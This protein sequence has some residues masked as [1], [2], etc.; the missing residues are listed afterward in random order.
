MVYLTDIH[1]N[2][3]YLLKNYL[4]YLEKVLSKQHIRKTKQTIGQ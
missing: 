3:S 2:G 1:T 4:K